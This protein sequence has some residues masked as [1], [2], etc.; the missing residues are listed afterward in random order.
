M[1][2][3]SLLF[4]GAVHEA[5]ASL[6]TFN[7][8][9][10]VTQVVS[11]LPEFNQTFFP[12]QAIFGSY[13]F[14]SSTPDASPTIETRGFYTDAVKSLTVTIGSFGG[15]IGVPNPSVPGTGIQ[16]WNNNPTDD[17]FVIVPTTGTTIAGYAPTFTEIH[18]SKNDGTL[19]SSKALP[20][21]SPSLSGLDIQA[22]VLGF[23]NETGPSQLI[24]GTVT[25]LTPVPLPPSAFLFGVGL[26]W[27]ARLALRK[28]RE[29]QR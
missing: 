9:G 19:L 22:F 25:S 16:V 15:T 20:I 24:F 7:F 18:L 28:S 10:Q 2:L 12:S 3:L 14:E 23:Q 27:L 11:N 26:S 29:S 21:F 13:T 8:E 6:V 1:A 5:E 17:Y 4:A